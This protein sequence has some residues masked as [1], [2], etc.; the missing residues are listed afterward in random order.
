MINVLFVCLGNICRSPMAEAV[1]NHLVEQEGL[2]SQFHIDSVGTASYHV[3]EPAHRGTRRVLADHGINSTCISR[4]INRRD[5]E[6]A[7]Y[8]VAMDRSNVSDLQ[9]TSRGLDIDGRLSLL[10]GFAPGVSRQDVP[11]PYYSG[12]FE[13]TYQ[14]V[15]A[16]CRGLLAHIRQEQGI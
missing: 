7:D 5:L 13:E 9:Y 12:N 1:F 3:G 14:L 2:S 8:I 16:G 15:D 4:Q 10:L 6:T 11:D